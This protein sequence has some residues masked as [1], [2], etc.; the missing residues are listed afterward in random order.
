[1]LRFFLAITP[2]IIWAIAALTA[3]SK[4]EAMLKDKDKQKEH[5]NLLSA[6]SRWLGRV[7]ALYYLG[8][9]V[10]IIFSFAA[11]YVVLP[12]RQ[13][14]HGTAR[15]EF[16]P[17]TEEADVILAQLESHIK[18]T[19]RDEY[20]LGK[21]THGDWVINIE[22]IKITK[23]DVANFPEEI[24]FPIEYWLVL[25]P[26]DINRFLY[27]KADITIP[28]DKRMILGDMAYFAPQI[29]EADNMVDLYPPVPS[30][31]VFFQNERSGG[32][33]ALIFTLPIELYWQINDFGE[34]YLGFPSSTR[35]HWARML[36]FSAGVATSNALGDIVPLTFGARIL[37]TLEA[38]LAF[39]FVG[40]F[41]NSLGIMLVSRSN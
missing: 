37:V 3:L 22:L 9:Y 4:H 6:T 5:R 13:F 33:E 38:I 41:L 14:Y 28:L 36:Y 27:Q 24:G 23:L 35:G 2:V 31:S 21:T 10:F 29:N 12:G 19:F 26:E 8:I 34:G 25:L 39:I 32:E 20:P 16:G 40:L 30:A 18:E 1:M 11:I 17:L 15:Y 7:P